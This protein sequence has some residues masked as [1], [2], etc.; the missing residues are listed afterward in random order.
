MKPVVVFGV[1]LGATVVAVGGALL[2]VEPFSPDAS[3]LYAVP[4][5]IFG[6]YV[7][8]S[9]TWIRDLGLYGWVFGRLPG[10][11]H[12]VSCAV[13]FA[14]VGGAVVYLAKQPPAGAAAVVRAMPGLSGRC[15]G[16]PEVRLD[17]EV[18][19]SAESLLSLRD[20]QSAAMQ[21]RLDDALQS[22][23]RRCVDQ[24]RVAFADPKGTHSSWR[25]FR[26]WVR[27]HPEVV[28]LPAEDPLWRAEFRQRE[29]ERPPVK[30]DLIP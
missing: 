30:L 7:V 11:V 26:D 29:R 6:L 5:L 20:G 23:I 8:V 10:A 4:P 28:T 12:A 1:L 22:M 15:V 24:A 3:V 25:R 19:P 16:D 14:L 17:R 27:D 21:R 13:G 9:A 18:V 2:W